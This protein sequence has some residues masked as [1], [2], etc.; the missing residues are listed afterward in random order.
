MRLGGN[1]FSQVIVVRTQVWKSISHLIFPLHSIEMS[2][3]PLPPPTQLPRITVQPDYPAVLRDI[4]QV[5]HSPSIPFLTRSHFDPRFDR[6]YT[7]WKTFGYHVMPRL[8]FMDECGSLRRI[9][10]EFPS[11]LEMELRLLKYPT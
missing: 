11:L 3:T 10:T 8:V 4:H 1:R 6:V 9:I 5:S 7:L 2:S